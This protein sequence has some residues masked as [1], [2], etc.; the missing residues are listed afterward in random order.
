[1]KRKAIKISTLGEIAQP[2]E[3][4]KKES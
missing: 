3:E 1:M 2:T 4:R